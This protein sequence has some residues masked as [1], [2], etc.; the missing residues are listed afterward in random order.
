M[1][2]PYAFS[3]WFPW[4]LGCWLSA[5]GL[6]LMAWALFV[7][8]RSRGRRR[9]PRCWYSLEG[10]PEAAGRWTCPEC[11]RPIAR[12]RRLFRTRRY[13]WRSLGGFAVA[14]AG[15]GTL[16][17]AQFK[18]RDLWRLVPDIVV[19]NA[20]PTFN[21]SGHLSREFSR[22]HYVVDDS[23]QRYW[24]NLDIDPD[25]FRLAPLSRPARWLL[26][27]RALEVLESNANSPYCGTLVPIVALTCTD[28]AR[29]AGAIDPLIDSPDWGARRVAV[30]FLPVV[31]SDDDKTTRRF[32]ARIEL[33]WAG[34]PQLQSDE[35]R[36][37][38]ALI[39]SSLQRMGARAAQGV[40][41]LIR[42]FPLADPQRGAG[43]GYQG[44]FIPI[45]EALGSIG[46]AAAEALPLLDPGQNMSLIW[47]GDRIERLVAVL[48]ISGACADEQAALVQLCSHPIWRVRR[49]AAG[50]LAKLGS[51]TDAART[52]LLSLLADEN[53]IVASSAV[54]SLLKL[55]LERD[56]CYEALLRPGDAWTHVQIMWRYGLDPTPMIPELEKDAAGI[57]D[58]RRDNYLDMINRIQT[59][60]PF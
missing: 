40:P 54:E 6:L 32:M 42:L 43:M 27:H 36:A 35:A 7:V 4:L 41:L 25:D 16:L 22:R 8:G 55:G 34:E 48:R 21:G 10:V 2:L 49:A 58:S 19:I 38:I 56:A 47:D 3:S 51:V 23:P 37:E 46:P 13:W 12:E 57:P 20:L 44:V 50:D 39:V 52:A 30:A 29:A 18:D 53:G 9:C 24:S 1:N 60:R 33:I 26:A 17:F 28:R 14:T 59:N 15:V 11:G 45:T 5:T 31:Q